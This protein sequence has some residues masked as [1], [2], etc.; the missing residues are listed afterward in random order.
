MLFQFLAIMCY[1]ILWNSIECSMFAVHTQT[2][3]FFT[4]THVSVTQLECKHTNIWWIVIQNET[5]SQGEAASLVCARVCMRAWVHTHTQLYCHVLSAKRLNQTIETKSD[6]K[7][8]HH[9]IIVNKIV[10]LQHRSKLPS[11][12]THKGDLN[13]TSLTHYQ[14][15]LLVVQT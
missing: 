3:A 15:S 8:E 9:Q 1:A 4:T 14:F 7:P 10:K 5:Y 2:Y 11:N 12:D 13:L 6:T